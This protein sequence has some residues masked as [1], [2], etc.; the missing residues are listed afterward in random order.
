MYFCLVVDD[1]LWIR[2]GMVNRV[3]RCE[4]FRAIRTEA[5][6]RDALTWLEGRG[7]SADILVSDVRMPHMDGLELIGQVKRRFPGMRAIVISSYD[8][9]EYAKQGIALGAVDYIVKPVNPDDLERALH[10]AA[11]QLET[12]R[13]HE[14][15]S[16][17][18]R[19][20]SQPSTQELMR[21][22]RERPARAERDALPLLV[23]DTL[24]VLERWAGD[25][26]D[27]L[28]PLAE[29]WIAGI[30]ETRGGADVFDWMKGALARSPVPLVEDLEL[31]RR[32]SGVYRLELALSWFGSRH[33][34]GGSAAGTKTVIDVKRYIERHYARKLSLQ[35]IA[36]A[37][38]V[39]KPHLSQV[40]R[41][42]TGMTIW[43]WLI[44]VRMRRAKELLLASDM[45]QAEIAEAVGYAD[46]A[47]FAKVFKAY[48]GMNATE[49]KSRYYGELLA[50]E[51]GPGGEGPAAERD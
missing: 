29:A 14:A 45:R 8:D 51:P 3:N 2:Q 9:F 49:L 24:A 48:Y 44:E 22:W 4:G 18:L 38:N 1:E 27:L 26:R 20:Y 17:L 31:Y 50:L 21:Q 25:R 5:N 34:A 30:A 39:S 47:H 6:G 32:L 7:H 10:A 11:E 28:S 35:V 19:A 33:T 13:R 37:V 36:D 40:F 41:Q 16:I 43:S 42:H 15:R 46:G 12:M 23:V